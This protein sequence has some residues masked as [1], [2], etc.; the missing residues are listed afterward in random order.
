V[1]HGGGPLGA[2]GCAVVRATIVLALIGVRVAAA[3]P[4][5]IQVEY[6]APAG[7]PSEAEVVTRLHERANV[8]RVEVAG[9]R[10]F[11]FAITSD[12]VAYRGELT[13][14]A[15][16]ELTTREVTA[17][18]CDEVAGALVVVAALALQQ[19]IPVA[20]AVPVSPA[21]WRFAAGAGV[22]RY[23]GVT[24]SARIGVPIYLATGH[25][26]QALRATFDLTTTD[27]APMASF[28]WLAGRIE[29]C[30]YVW[31]FGRLAAAPCAGLQ[32]GALRGKG[33]VAFE[34]M[35][36]TRPWVA[37]EAVGRIGIRLSGF[38]LEL[39]G[40]IAAPL[41]RDRYYIAPSTTIYQVPA[42][43]YGVATT[44]GIEFP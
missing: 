20:R 33:T 14:D 21:R 3:G 17:A 10:R 34:A 43:A 38:E 44:L 35:S 24:P 5:P 4:E 13:I 26:H 12:G 39:E 36:E 19:Q 11:A 29:A 42:I 1:E 32:L 7:C 8:A 15:D 18:T 23:A 22:A 9:A 2:V 25:G 28:Q 31:R 27:D 16:G 40:A 41:V 30:P 37:P 6:A